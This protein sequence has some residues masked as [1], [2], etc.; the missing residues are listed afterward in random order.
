MEDQLFF[1]K[2]LRKYV[3]KKYSEPTKELIESPYAKLFISKK[4]LDKWFTYECKKLRRKQFEFFFDQLIKK[5]ENI[6]STELTRIAN[7]KNDRIIKNKM[8]V[9]DIYGRGIIKKQY[10]S[11]IAF[12][13]T[14]EESPAKEKEFKVFVSGLNS[15]SKSRFGK[16]KYESDMIETVE[17]KKDDPFHLEAGRRDFYKTY[18]DQKRKRKLKKKKLRKRK[19]QKKKTEEELKKDFQRISTTY[20]KDYEFMR[21]NQSPFQK[22]L[23]K[24]MRPVTVHT[25]KRRSNFVDT[26]KRIFHVST[27]PVGKEKR[28][29][30]TSR[31]LSLSNA[32]AIERERNSFLTT[33]GTFYKPRN[34]NEYR[35]RRGFKLDHSLEV[36]TIGAVPTYVKRMQ[37]KKMKKR[38]SEPVV[39]KRKRKQNK[40]DDSLLKFGLVGRSTYKN[41]FNSHAA[42]GISVTQLESF[43]N[44]MNG[45]RVPYGRSYDDQHANL[46]MRTSSSTIGN[47]N[48]K[49]KRVGT[50]A[51]ARVLN[52][53]TACC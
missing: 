45:K 52:G 26:K 48:W 24:P 6:S 41:T 8:K 40:R 10:Y 28:R 49:P 7:W 17:L 5:I 53:P 19:N 36:P 16:S 9:V 37:K 35:R 46:F 32:P 38:Y 13:F 44:R 14:K 30:L 3:E 33:T 22:R 20:R 42:F 2:Y 4:L 34:A 43:K 39:T 50:S 29:P 12:I 15:F 25:K 23:L 27:N 31:T 18:Y 1:K 21:E 47:H 11:R 51:V